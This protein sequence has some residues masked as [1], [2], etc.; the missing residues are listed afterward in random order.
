MS[1]YGH[2]PHNW[3]EAIVNKMGGEEGAERFLRDELVLSEPVRSWRED[4]GVI[5]FSVTSDGTTGEE[6][7]TRLEAKGF[8]VEDYDK[9]VL[10][11]SDFRP[12][13]DVTAEIAVL[14]GALFK[15]N[16]RTT[17]KIRTYAGR[18]KFG[19]LNAEVACLIREQFTDKEIGAMGL[20]WIV[21]MH[22]PI[23]ASDGY[24]YLLYTDRDAHGSWL[25]TCLGE[26]G[27]RWLR[28]N[29]FAFAVS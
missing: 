1:K 6:W 13:S 21:T 8:R 9:S 14:T 23:K 7:I 28:N 26:P 20:C 12:T 27:N 18:R 5:Y 15:D 10:R 2:R 24:S 3:F 11:S 19:K 17:K 25:R 29:G 22:E 16:D 4:N